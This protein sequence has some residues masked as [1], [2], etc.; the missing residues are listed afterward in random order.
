MQNFVHGRLP[1]G[2]LGSDLRGATRALL[3]RKRAT[4][5]RR[6]SSG[7]L[8]PALQ[9]PVVRIWT[10]DQPTGRGASR[11]AVDPAEV[12]NLTTENYHATRNVPDQTANTL[13]SV[14]AWNRL[15]SAAEQNGP[16]RRLGAFSSAACAAPRGDASRD[17]RLQRR[18]AQRRPQRV[19][20]A[21]KP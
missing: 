17:A 19:A 7:T 3:A 20:W 5:R 10:S 4:E 11:R 21:K 13:P 16:V 15:I 6:S 2:R 12:Q 1:Q 8:A 9:R 18:D 14:L